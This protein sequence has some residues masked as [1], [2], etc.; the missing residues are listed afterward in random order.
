MHE[1]SDPDTWL[2]QYGNTLYRHALLRLNNST[3]AEELVQETL[4]AALQAR[5]G[6]AGKSSEKTWLV[7]ILKHKIIDHLRRAAREQTVDCNSELEALLSE[8]FDEHGRWKIDVSAWSDPDK[9][10][11]SEQLRKVLEKCLSGLPERLSH[12]FIL[13]EI[14]GLNSSEICKVL[15]ISTTNNLWVMLSRMR[16]Q[17]RQCLDTHWFNN[18]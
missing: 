12:L 8:S 1:L 14:D 10:L 4:L 3:L 17:L 16:M 13:R 7:G 15:N 2:D 18:K 9:A 11:E 6:F 5:S